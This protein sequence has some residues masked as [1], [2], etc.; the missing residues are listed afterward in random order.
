MVM[1]LFGFGY[2]TDGKS[3]WQ[4]SYDFCDWLD[5]WTYY[6]SL[7]ELHETFGQYFSEIEHLED[8]FVERKFPN[9]LTKIA[10]ACLK[11]FFS[12]YLM[13]Q[14][15]VLSKYLHKE[16]GNDVPSSKG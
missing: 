16:H 11:R 3:V 8:R 5:K 12:R 10:P 9:F 7:S 6:R 13:T 1:R 4:W 14:V 2:F 15:F